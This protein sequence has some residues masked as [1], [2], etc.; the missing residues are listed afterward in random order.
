MNT[1]EINNQLNDNL[2]IEE[3]NYEE[4]TSEVLSD[5]DAILSNREKSLE[6]DEQ[7]DEAS[8]IGSVIVEEEGK[9][10]CE[11]CLTNTVP[12][13]SQ[14]FGTHFK[15][16]C[17]DCFSQ[18]QSTSSTAYSSSPHRNSIN[19]LNESLYA[20]SQISYNSNVEFDNQEINGLIRNL[21][22]GLVSFAEKVEENLQSKDA[23]IQN[24][25]ELVLNL[26]ANVFIHD[27]SLETQHRDTEWLKLKEKKHDNIFLEIQEEKL[28]KLK[29]EEGIK[30]S[31]IFYP[32]NLWLTVP[33][34]CLLT[35]L[36]LYFQ[37]F[38]KPTKSLEKTKLWEIKEKFNEWISN[39]YGSAFGYAFSFFIF[40]D[41]L[42]WINKDIKKWVKRS[43]FNRTSA[44]FVISLLLGGLFVIDGKI[45]SSLKTPL[46]RLGIKI[47][48]SK[49]DEKKKKTLLSKA[50]EA[51][52]TM[53]E[54]LKRFGLLA[55]APLLINLVKDDWSSSKFANICYLIPV[56]YS[57]K[58]VDETKKEMNEEPREDLKQ[59]TNASLI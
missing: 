38:Y 36:Y 15:P 7:S 22:S 58:L 41:G 53:K 3:P 39:T 52:E 21:N 46:Q 32:D 11:K 19:S 27:A 10:I 40:S 16:L 17:E 1:N 37:F 54:T 50:Q 5:L 56:L 47:E 29:R 20:F 14:E 33:I 24:L 31:N 4:R 43:S 44:I 51:N 13:Y 42:Y 28:E 25:K 35:P 48:N 49:L 12:I 30:K 18:L 57:W 2:V 55:F 8:E 26:N 9:I 45:T 59:T 6:A 34:F 23:E